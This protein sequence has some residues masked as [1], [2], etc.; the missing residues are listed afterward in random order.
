MDQSS[1]SGSMTFITG[2]GVTVCHHHL[3][4]ESVI[5]IQFV[6]YAFG[7]DSVQYQVSNWKGQSKCH[8]VAAMFSHSAPSASLSLHFH[9]AKS[10]DKPK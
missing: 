1:D 7:K 3:S 5:I 8:P 2:S 6:F 9:D 10:C 4:P